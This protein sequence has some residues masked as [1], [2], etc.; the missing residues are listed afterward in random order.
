MDPRLGTALLVVIG[1]PAIIVGYIYGTE[2]ALRA[3]SE[4]Q[5]SRFR[6][7]LWL[8]PALLFLFAFLVWPTILTILRSF[9]G[10]AGR[11]L[12]RARQLR[13]VLHQQR[14]AHLAPE[15]RALG[16]PADPVHGRPRVDHRRPRGP[17]PLRDGRQVDHLRSAGDQHDRRRRHLAVH[18]RVPVQGTAPDRHARRRRRPSSG[19]TRSPGSSSTRSPSTRSS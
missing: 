19:S 13:L 18:V 17:C 12:G 3:F 8:L 7:W 9:Q 5:R 14:R 4:R 15:Q 11:Q 16:R 10:R 6:P 2:I 1:V